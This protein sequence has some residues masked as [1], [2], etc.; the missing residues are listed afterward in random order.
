MIWIFFFR[1]ILKNLNWTFHLNEHR[2]L[3]VV[4]KSWYTN[5]KRTQ[6]DCIYDQARCLLPLICRT[7][8]TIWITWRKS[9]SENCSQVVIQKRNLPCISDCIGT[10]TKKKKKKTDTFSKLYWTESRKMKQSRNSLSISQPTNHYPIYGPCARYHTSQKKINQQNKS[11]IYRTTQK[12][13]L[14]WSH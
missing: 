4:C 12:R 11:K 5:G 13:M 8:H 9:K 6:I 3:S 14:T 2:D 7:T 10:T 1:C